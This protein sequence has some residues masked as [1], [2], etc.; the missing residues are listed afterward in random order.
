MLTN[1]EERWRKAS[2]PRGVQKIKKQY[3]DSL[4]KVGRIPDIINPEDALDSSED[5]TEAWHVQVKILHM[6]AL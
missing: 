3:D 2:K 4:L 6:S 1:F 5:D